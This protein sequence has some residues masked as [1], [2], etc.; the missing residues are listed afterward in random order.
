LD[1]LD[2]AILRALQR[3]GRISN[4]ELARRI[5]LSPPA[6]LSRVRRLEEEGF[7]REYVALLNQEAVGYQMTCFI[8]VSLQLHQHEELEEFHATIQAIPA[9]L[10]CYHV[11]GEFDYL[12]KVVV[13]S[14]Q[15]LQRLI[16][17]QLT[18]L[19]GVAR[20]YTSLVLSA[21]KATTELPLTG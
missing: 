20:I 6:T 14:R 15:D 2:L 11:T 18:P 9:V 17:N 12:L 4:V 8:S 7:I 19:P 5:D 3:D 21:V 10:E 13:R 1:D 16:V